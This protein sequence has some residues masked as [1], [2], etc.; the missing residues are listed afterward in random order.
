MTVGAAASWLDAKYIDPRDPNFGLVPVGVAD[1]QFSLFASYELQKGDWRGLGLG[2][3]YY[4]ISDRSISYSTEQFVDGYERADLNGFYRG[5]KNWNFSLQV[6]N[7]LD[8]TYVERFRQ[9][10]FGNFFGSPRAA[11]LRVEYKFH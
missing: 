4:S 8:K 1:R 11:L 6:R 9:P 2:A 7:L 5:L 10:G 3:T